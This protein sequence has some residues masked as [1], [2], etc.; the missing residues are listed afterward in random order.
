MRDVVRPCPD[1]GT[2]VSFRIRGHVPKDLALLCTECWRKRALDVQ[3][4]RSRKQDLRKPTARR[5]PTE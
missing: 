2:R 4:E 5:R 1:C 3:A